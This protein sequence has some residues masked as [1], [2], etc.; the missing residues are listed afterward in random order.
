M[1]DEEK[2]ARAS[3]LLALADECFDVHGDCIDTAEYEEFTEGRR[4]VYLVRELL[5]E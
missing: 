1:F 5:S 4:Y 2:Q 3:K